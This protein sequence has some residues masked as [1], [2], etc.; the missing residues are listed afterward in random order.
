[1]SLV[2]VYPTILETA[3]LSIEPQKPGRSLI[4]IANEPDDKDRVIFAEYHAMGSKSGAFMIRKGHWKYIH[5]V[6][7]KP[8]LFDL[9]CD[10]DEISDLSDDHEF[11]DVIK[12][13]ES[14]LRL[15]CDPKTVDQTAKTDQAKIIELNGGVEAVVKK[16]GFG[17]T[18]P[19]GVNPEYASTKS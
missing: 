10:P 8:Q 6:S 18:P 1:M 16:G 19:P 2:D 11:V 9:E 17:A 7:M 13:L 14:E 3:K 5:Y 15:I 4:K 12:N